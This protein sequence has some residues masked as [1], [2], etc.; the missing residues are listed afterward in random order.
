MRK[1]LNEL[2]KEVF[3]E[4]KLIPE[5]EFKRMVEEHMN[6]E[7]SELLKNSGLRFTLG[8]ECGNDCDE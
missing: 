6:G 5:D 8:D 3:D 4:L 1:R 7:I 2:I